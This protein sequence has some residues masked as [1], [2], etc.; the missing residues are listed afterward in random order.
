MSCWLAPQLRMLPLAIRSCFV[1]N[2]LNGASLQLSSG[3]HAVLSACDGCGTLEELTMPGADGSKPFLEAKHLL[4][5]WQRQYQ[6]QANGQH[7][8]LTGKPDVWS[9][10]PNGN[11]QYG[12]W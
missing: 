10:G 8:S 3:E 6:Y 2:P 9:A 7:N 5:P 1:R 11:M 12:N 4:D